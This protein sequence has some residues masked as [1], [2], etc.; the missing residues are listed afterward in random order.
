MT[1]PAACEFPRRLGV[2][3]TAQL[4]NLTLQSKAHP[5]CAGRALALGRPP[6]GGRGGSKSLPTYPPWLGQSNPR[7]R[8]ASP[9]LG[10]PWPSQAAPNPP[11]FEGIK[12]TSALNISPTR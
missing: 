9:W 10:L 1:F 12:R 5:A 6:P 4:E 11:G 8:T 2:E 7:T 3:K